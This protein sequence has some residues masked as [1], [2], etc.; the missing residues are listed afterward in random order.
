VFSGDVY[1]SLEP[2]YSIETEFSLE[3]FAGS[4]NHPLL[5]LAA[6]SFGA[7][8]GAGLAF[9][10]SDGLVL[11][12]R[13]SAVKAGAKKAAD[14]AAKGGG[15]AVELTRAQSR[16]INTLDNTLPAQLKNSKCINI[17]A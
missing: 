14:S 16:N 5:K 13:G 12:K 6:D 2:L 17:V 9:G 1:G 7:G 15:K 3:K 8:A 10:I 4:E 11:A